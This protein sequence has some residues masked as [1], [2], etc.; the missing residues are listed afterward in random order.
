MKNT[1]ARSVKRE[2]E[3]DWGK[4]GDDRNRPGRAF[5]VV[6]DGVVVGPVFKHN[7]APVGRAAPRPF[8]RLVGHNGSLYRYLK[9]NLSGIQSNRPGYFFGE[10]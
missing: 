4:H 10:T 6:A 3:E 9:S 5:D 7:A 2:A 1:N 8:G